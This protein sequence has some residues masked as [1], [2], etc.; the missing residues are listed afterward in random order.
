MGAGRAGVP[1]GAVHSLKKETTMD[2]SSFFA[3]LRARNS[4]VFGTSLSQQ[5]VEGTESLL[6]ALDGFT[7][8][9]A[10]HVLAEVYHETG[11]GMW[12]VK[13]TVYRT[14][15]DRD[16]SD[17]Q[18]I[19]R[20]NV[21]WAKGQLPW[22]RAPYWRDGWFG[23][24]QIQLTHAENYRNASALVG[25]DLVSDPSRALEPVVSAKIAAEGCRS[26]MFTGKR[27]ADFDGPGGYDHA[28]ARSIVNGDTRAMGP[29]IAGHAA[30]FEAALDAAGW[31]A[32]QPPAPDYAPPAPDAVEIHPQS[33]VWAALFAALARLFKGA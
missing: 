7:L 24:G 15:K 31:G 20:L 22:V 14:S 13:E 21:A 3:A 26:G 10:A 32:A 6:D 27:L 9:H 2:R 19:A 4:G 12:P 1:A 25:V 5:Q 28:A 18:V 17:A 8:P 29:T 33:T 16:P 11:G 23:R 30:A